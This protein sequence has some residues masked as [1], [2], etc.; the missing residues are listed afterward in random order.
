[1]ALKASN[2]H[3][4]FRYLLDIESINLLWT[5]RIVTDSEFE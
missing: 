5:S 4:F 3:V 2:D 1:L